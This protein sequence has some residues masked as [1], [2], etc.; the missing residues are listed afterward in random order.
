MQKTAVCWREG[1]TI[2]PV[3]DI[4]SQTQN[5]SVAY[6]R[7]FFNTSVSKD[8]EFY[9]LHHCHCTTDM[10]IPIQT[11]DVT[12]YCIGQ[13]TCLC[14]LCV[15]LICPFTSRETRALPE[16]ALFGIE[17]SGH[18]HSFTHSQTHS[19]SHS[20]HSQTHIHSHT[21]SHTHNSNPRFHDVPC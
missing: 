14:T 6:N 4:Q 5:S 11:S 2:V 15:V 21:H 20:P 7:T 18:T 1:F 8:T 9:L 19:H 16:T 17:V 12:Q 10:T 3:K 13:R